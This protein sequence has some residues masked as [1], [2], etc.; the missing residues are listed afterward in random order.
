MANR[1]MTCQVDE[2]DSAV[3]ARGMC[4]KH[5]LRFRKYGDTSV[6]RPSPKR[7]AVCTKDDCNRPMSAKG[8]CETHYNAAWRAIVAST[9]CAV[10]G[11][12]EGAHTFGQ[13]RKHYEAGLDRR[14]TLTCAT[15]G[16]IETRTLSRNGKRAATCSK[17]C[18]AA[19]TA[20]IKRDG[21]Q[22][23]VSVAVRNGDVETF[24]NLIRQRV[25][26]SDSGCW[27]WQGYLQY[28]YGN[29]RCNSKTWPVHRLVA[30]MTDEAYSA[31]L[32]VHHAC[33]NRAC[34]NPD[35]I[36][37]VTPHDN[38]AEMFERNSYK[39]RIKALEMALREHAPSHPLLAVA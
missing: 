39:R 11:C 20:S 10:G 13:C 27:E 24:L 33:A 28:G 15:C 34:C 37:V 26:V 38:T 2:C 22:S 7:V 5:Y 23:Q 14:Y 3:L 18:Q 19:H 30:S 17:P 16:K 12:T 1:D 9:P 31:H 4:N 25:K 6:S 21:P 32:A 29:T 36:K 35:H 8:L